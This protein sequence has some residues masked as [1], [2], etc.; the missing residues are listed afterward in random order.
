MTK[1]LYIKVQYGTNV[2]Y[3]PFNKS[4]I[5][6]TSSQNLRQPVKEIFDWVQ[7]TVVS[8]GQTNAVTAAIATVGGAAFELA[9]ILGY[10]LFNKDYY[11]NAWAGSNPSEFALSSELIAGWKGLYDGK[12]EVVDPIKI[13]YAYTV[14][15]TTSGKKDGNGFLKSP[16]PNA[17]KAVSTFI[18]SYISGLKGSTT[19]KTLQGA[20]DEAGK[21][22]HGALTAANALSSAEGGVG[23]AAQAKLETGAT[24]EVSFLYYD[25]IGS[26][27]KIFFTVPDLIAQT[28]TINLDPTLVDSNGS[29][30][31]GTITINFKSNITVRDTVL[32][33]MFEV[34]DDFTDL[35]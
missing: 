6:H 32:F 21:G 1:G 10:K 13:L 31:R 27:G 24:W 15:D 30:C 29:P 5:D 23:A 28:A 2:E 7:Q 34:R 18:D 14:P 19:D 33:K 3:L 25:G 12:L 11:T 8:V 17:V 26:K 4:T 35:K 20:Y 16:G 9:D 22:L